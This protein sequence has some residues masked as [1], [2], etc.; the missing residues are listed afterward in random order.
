[1]QRASRAL[2]GLILFLA[3]WCVPGAG[4]QMVAP[5]SLEQGF[6]I[7]VEDRSGKASDDRPIYLASN[8]VGWNPGASSM[9]L[10]RGSDGL[11]RIEMSKPSSSE[12]MQFKFTLGDW[13]FVEQDAQGQDIP[14]RT[15]PMVDVSGLAPG[16]KPVLRFVVETFREPED[17]PGL[18]GGLDPYR[19]LD[20][21]GI[22]RRLQV[23]GGAG[24]ARGM[25]RDL[26]VWLPPGYDEPENAS[27][28]YPVLYMQDGQNLFEKHGGIPDEWHADET[29]LE[30]IQRGEIRPLIIVGIPHGGEARMEEY[31]P[32][33]IWTDYEPA[34]D[35][36]VAWLFDEVMPRVERAFRVSTRP[37]ETFIG[38]SSL[39]A[40]ISIHAHVRHPS[41]FG[42]LLLESLP[43]L[44]GAR[45]EWLGQLGRV[46]VWPRRIYLGVGDHEVG[47]SDRDAPL[48]ERYVAWT[49]RFA[50]FLRDH[51]VQDERLRVVIGEGQ[52]HN[53]EAW[54][55]RFADALRFL[56]PARNDESR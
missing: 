56:L 34:G 27:R 50:D 41:R 42:G 30:L 36:Y 16:Q 12:P 23:A 53:E 2:F 25:T 26:L 6:V 40:V 37:E 8:H 18:A 21:S 28:T 52:T 15:L 17:A 55:Q 9:R 20:V 14:N 38:G 44:K 54:S 35:A 48:N 47:F 45:D 51:G 33:R 3:A 19:T 43:T 22:V 24:M 49:R 7:V 31:V 13:A 10:V 4:A 29:A 11:W 46:A 39:G 1:M 32:L 5:E